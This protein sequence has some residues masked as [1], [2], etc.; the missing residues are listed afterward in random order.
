MQTFD[1]EI[2]SS[3]QLTTKWSLS[4]VIFINF[5]Y[6]RGVHDRKK[7]LVSCCYKLQ[8][9][10]FE[11]YDSYNMNNYS[12]KKTQYDEKLTDEVNFSIMIIL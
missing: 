3:F 6:K 1:H 4:V 11:V 5:L 10:H 12:Y 7:S 2:W 8:E 9:E